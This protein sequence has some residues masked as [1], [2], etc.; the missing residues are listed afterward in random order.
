M[1]TPDHP[2]D[3]YDLFSE[4]FG[5]DA[6]AQW[7]ALRSSGCPVAHSELRGGSW[8]LSRY[9]DIQSVAQD[10]E[11][12]TSRAL[13]VSGPV[14]PGTGLLM[15][16]LTSNAEDHPLHRAVL[17][18]FFTPAR[19]A[20][21]EP[22]VRNEAR[23][24][25]TA[26]ARRGHGDAAAEYAR[27]LA[28]AVLTHLLQVP[29]DM[30]D[31][32]VD[33]AIRVIRVGPL[34]QRVRSEAIAEAI[35]DLE[36]LLNQRTASPGEDIVSHIAQARIN[37]EP[38]SRKHK[39]GSLILLVLAGADTTWSTIGA[40]VYHLGLHPAD[41]ARLLAEP[42]LLKTSA[43]EELLRVYAPLS[44]ARITDSDAELH[45]RCIGAG[46]RV[47][48][49]YAAANRDPAV[50]DEPDTVDLARKRNRHL[51]FGSGIH[52][53]LGAPLARLE[54]RVAIE[55]WLAQIPDYTL[56]EPTAV[57]WTKGQIRGPERVLFK[58]QG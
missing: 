7:A 50:F 53:C 29:R 21:L 46:E 49:Q 42:A 57:P 47:V 58:T 51:T 14:T 48:L 33:W 44:A 55:E 16:P 26:L 43:V 5:L 45:G 6:P 41:R 22:F 34:D 4:E 38:L 1:P 12:F 30:Q 17:A 37:G 23:R 25:V 10:P 15:P 36:T 28:L 52:R 9:D 35:A 2:L 32:F 31:R 18:P 20:G 39:V 3:G 54:T 27:P 40:S 24:L 11:R 19:V 56:V 13:E 8:L